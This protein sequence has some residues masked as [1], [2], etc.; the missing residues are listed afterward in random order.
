MTWEGTR[1][2][3]PRCVYH[4]KEGVSLNNEIICDSD[5]WVPGNPGESQVNVHVACRGHVGLTAERVQGHTVTSKRI[6]R[7]LQK[8]E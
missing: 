2:I 6:P 5:D 1:R 8:S 7:P 4:G 3:S